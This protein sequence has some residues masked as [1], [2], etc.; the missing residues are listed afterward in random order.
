MVR[1]HPGPLASCPDTPIGRA[2]RLGHRRAALVA[3]CL[4]VRF[5]LWA[6]TTKQHGALVQREDVCFARRK[7]GFDSPVLHSLSRN[8]EV[9]QRRAACL[10][11][12]CLRVRLP[13]SVLRR[14][15]TARYANWQ[16]G[17]FQTFVFEGST[18]S[19]ATENKIETQ[20]SGE[21]GRHATLRKSGRLRRASS[22]LA[23]ATLLQMRQVPNWLS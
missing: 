18:P 20:P 19:L 2:I 1:L 23:L 8:A 5:L 9:G 11:N 22:T 16:S 12:K 14:L 17:E 10:R 6:L 21:T 3:G 7:S 13:P 4:Q 15:I